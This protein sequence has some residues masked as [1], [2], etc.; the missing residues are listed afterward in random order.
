MNTVLNLQSI[1]DAYAPPKSQGAQLPLNQSYYQ[2]QMQES[3]KQ[4]TAFVCPLGF[5]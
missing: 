3:D 1:K 5:W 2:I 4:K